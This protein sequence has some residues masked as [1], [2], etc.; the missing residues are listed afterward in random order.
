MY[1]D[2]DRQVT[3]QTVHVLL[4]G[5][6]HSTELPHPSCSSPEGPFK[7]WLVLF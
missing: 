3:L 5:Q 4:L 1:L 2:R 6:P 7:E